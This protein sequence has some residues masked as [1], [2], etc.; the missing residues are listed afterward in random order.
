M[1]ICSESHH[2]VRARRAQ[3]SV[4]RTYFTSSCRSIDPIYYARDGHE[5]DRRACGTAASQQKPAI[6]DIYDT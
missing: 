5:V 3:C 6:L 4:R 2:N 1:W